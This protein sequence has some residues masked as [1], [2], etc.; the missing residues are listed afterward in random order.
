MTSVLDRIAALLGEPGGRGNEP[1]DGAGT[2]T[3]D[4]SDVEGSDTGVTDSSTTPDHERER[5]DR[6]VRTVAA[7]LQSSPEGLRKYTAALTVQ[8]GEIAAVE[9]G[10]LVRQFQVREGGVGSG[11]VRVRAV[12]FNGEARH[13]DAAAPLFTVRFDRPVPADGVS[14]SVESAT[15]H[16][17]EPVPG[18]RFR[19]TVV[20]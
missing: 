5:E 17:L 8:G 3:D 16:A 2:V 15:D 13:V 11:F 14:L 18:D 4:D 1:D 6:E 7:V 19:L 20:E 10:V 12:D 9:P